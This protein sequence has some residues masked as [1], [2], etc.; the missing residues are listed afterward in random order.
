MWVGSSI[1]VCTLILLCQRLPEGC[2]NGF[3]IGKLAQ[4]GPFQ[5]FRPLPLPSVRI[6]QIGVHG[7]V[8]IGLRKIEIAGFDGGG[9]MLEKKDLVERGS[10]CSVTAVQYCPLVC[11]EEIRWRTWPNYAIVVF[12]PVDG[13]DEIGGAGVPVEADRAKD[14]TEAIL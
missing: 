2:Q 6:N 14:G 10:E 4:S 3:R 12:E 9:N 7:A 13:G 5:Q 1:G 11:I 8:F